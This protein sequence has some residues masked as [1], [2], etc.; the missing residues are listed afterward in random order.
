MR[1][2]LMFG[3]L[4]AAVSLI[5]AG[6]T[7]Q[8]SAQDDADVANAWSTGTSDGLALLESMGVEAR[9]MN[10]CHGS[11]DDLGKKCSPGFTEDTFKLAAE[12]WCNQYLQKFTVPTHQSYVS[13]FVALP[14]NVND[15]NGAQCDFVGNIRVDR[16]TDGEEAHWNYIDAPRCREHIDDIWKKCG[17]FGGWWNTSWGTVFMECSAKA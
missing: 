4:L 8:D 5:L 9:A 12:V 11:D 6:S 16:D 1:F 13:R 10:G 2:T 15:P 14:C 7:A 3:F 17:G